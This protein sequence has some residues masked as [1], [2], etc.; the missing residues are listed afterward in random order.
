[1]P[2]ISGYKHSTQ[3][4][5]RVEL[6]GMVIDFGGT[7]IATARVLEGKIIAH[8]IVATDG[9]ASIQQ[10]LDTMVQ[11]VQSL[12]LTAE[13]LVT[14]AVSGRIDTHGNWY[15][16]N[17]NT[18]TKIDRVPLRDLL[19]TSL[20]RTVHVVNDTVAGAL[21]EAHFGAGENADNQVYV[22]V[23][24]G[25]GGVCVINGMPLTSPSGIAGHAGFMSSRFGSEVCGSGRVATVE[26]TAS[27]NA[28]AAAA[29]ALGYAHMDGKQVYQAHLNGEPWATD[30]VQRS[31]KAVA[32]LLVNI[33]A[34]I[35]TELAIIGGSVGLAEGYVDLVEGYIKQEPSL[36]QLSV[37][38]ASLDQYSVLLGAMA[39][40]RLYL[41]RNGQCV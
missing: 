15:A 5:S 9:N 16:V 19:S 11:L 1:M 23:S 39:S 33:R 31:A 29:T 34:L 22:T 25:V 3:M 27:G 28:L 26:S 2:H 41:S 8:E 32:D 40:H 10:Q 17:A 36:F 13:D 12:D 21:G 37:K 38:P 18:L 24:T 4:P 30:I 20:N 35:G 7:K 6:S 14:V